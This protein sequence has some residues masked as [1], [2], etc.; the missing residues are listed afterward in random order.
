MDTRLDVLKSSGS[1]TG[2]SDFPLVRQ[3]WVVVSLDYKGKE[4]RKESGV[5]RKVKQVVK[6]NGK[7]ES[8]LGRIRTYDQSVMSRPLCR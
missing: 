3:D 5:V 1:S 4:G 8:G 2:V 6:Q 7:V